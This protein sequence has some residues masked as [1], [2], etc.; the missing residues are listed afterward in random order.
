M[1]RLEAKKK[2]SKLCRCKYAFRETASQFFC[3]FASV[4][5]TIIFRY[6]RIFSSVV[7]VLINKA[8][9]Q[10]IRSISLIKYLCS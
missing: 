4:E 1:V 6:L 2:M 8:R 10:Q 3:D 7:S 5:I 9:H